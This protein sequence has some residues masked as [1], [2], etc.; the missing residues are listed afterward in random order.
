MN[1]PAKKLNSK[2]STI[3]AWMVFW[4]QA[5]CST[6]PVPIST[7]SAIDARFQFERN[8]SA[9]TSSAGVSSP[10]VSFYQKV[11]SKTLGSHCSLYPNDS[12]YAQRVH[13]RCG[14]GVATLRSMSRFYFEPD[15]ATLG[16]P[17]IQKNGRVLFKDLPNDCAIF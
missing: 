9:E 1:S 15:A 8:A 17:L 7:L 3:V 12:A 10:G 14:A 11:L 6:V 4:A 16:T 13:A 2:S 5:S